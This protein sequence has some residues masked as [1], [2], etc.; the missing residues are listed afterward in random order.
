MD[1]DRCKIWTWRNHSFIS[2]VMLSK[3]TQVYH[4]CWR[5]YE[6][7]DRCPR[8]VQRLHFLNPHAPKEHLRYSWNLTETMES[9][10]YGKVKPNF[11]WSHFQGNPWFC[12]KLTWFPTWRMDVKSFVSL[13]VDQI[14]FSHM[15]YRARNLARI[16]ESILAEIL[17]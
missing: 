2:S 12:V 11:S 1:I 14:C 10:S 15:K 7:F 9:M 17:P 3:S 6:N 8:W 16:R 5:S 13:H 4:R